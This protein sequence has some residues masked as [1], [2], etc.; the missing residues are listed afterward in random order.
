VILLLVPVVVEVVEVE[1]RWLRVYASAVAVEAEAP[2]ADVAEAAV[3]PA[4]P[5]RIALPIAITATAPMARLVAVL[6]A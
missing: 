1:R 3:A 2:V 5:A 6:I 4:F